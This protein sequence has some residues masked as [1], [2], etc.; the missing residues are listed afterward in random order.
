MSIFFPLV[1]WRSSM[2]ELLTC[3]EVVVGSIP[4]ASSTEILLYKVVIRV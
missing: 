1:S 4:I 2:V 3:N